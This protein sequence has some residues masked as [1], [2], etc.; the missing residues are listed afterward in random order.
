MIASLV[1]IGKDM[2][3]VTGKEKIFYED[4]KSPRECHISEEIDL[5]YPE[6]KVLEE[7][8]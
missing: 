3:K 2:G 7:T 1:D 8:A 5:E 6:S 4:Q